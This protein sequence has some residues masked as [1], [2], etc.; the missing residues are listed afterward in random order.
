MARRRAF[1]RGEVVFHRGDPA[2]ALHLIVKG[3]FAA[4]I[5][6]Q[7]GATVTVAIHSP[8]E[9]FGEL[10]L[11]ETGA[12]RSTTVA[13]VEAGETLAISRDDF[14]GLR[15]EYPEVNEVLVRLLAARVRHAT[16]SLLEALFV[17]AETRVLRRLL[18]LA[19][20]YGHSSGGTSIPLTQEDIAALA[21]TSRAT[22]NRVLRAEQE[23]G[24]VRLG[25]G[26]TVVL[27]PDG[28]ARRAQA[29]A[30]DRA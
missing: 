19:E 3:R 4:R 15:R 16:G 27:D 22:A 14:D 24:T 10:A 1:D 12:S 30:V 26:K 2:D 29:P 13:A 18:E 8:G 28:I 11:V 21:A 20:L 5:T 6:T 17:P 9:A 7:L 25:R 23:R